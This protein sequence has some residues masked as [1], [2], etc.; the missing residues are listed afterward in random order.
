MAVIHI[1]RSGL[2]T[3]TRSSAGW[4]AAL[5]ASHQL[6]IQ[7]S[8]AQKS[9]QR[10]QKQRLGHW[11]MIQC[12]ACTMSSG[13]SLKCSRSFA[14][15]IAIACFCETIRDSCA[16]RGVHDTDRGEGH[17][18]GT[19]RPPNF[20]IA[21]TCGPSPAAPTQFESKLVYRTAASHRT[22]PAV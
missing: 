13:S 18:T 11:N 20:L 10:L 16:S 3:S 22:L 2:W 19:A 15:N 6:Q 9:E 17:S 21:G 8:C 5:P 7:L 4:C 14:L 12:G 1:H